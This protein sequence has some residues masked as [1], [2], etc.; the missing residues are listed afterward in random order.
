ME[1]Q[2]ANNSTRYFTCPD[3]L[4]LPLGEDVLVYSSIIKKMSLLSNLKGTLLNHCRTPRTL[5]EHAL[6]CHQRLEAPVDVIKAQLTALVEEGHLL[7][8]QFILRRSRQIKPDDPPRKIDHIGVIT[9]NRPAQL[10]RCLSSYISNVRESGRH[11]SYVV[12]D[13]TRDTH[14]RSDTRC[15]LRALG[16]EHAVEIAYLG[17]EEKR[18]LAVRLAASGEIP[19]EVID[20]ALFDVD[21]CG[22]SI[23]ANRNALLLQT[24]GSLVLSTDDD[25]FC[26]IALP[27]GARNSLVMGDLENCNEHWFFPSR[28]VALKVVEFTDVD[29]L[30][31][32]EEILGADAVDYLSTLKGND[33]FEV[34]DLDPF[35]FRSLMSGRARIRFTYAG[36]I[37]DSALRSPIRFLF[38]DGPSRSRFL[39]NEELYRSA[40]RSREVMR[41]V[42]QPVLTKHSWCMTG[43]M[44]FDNR[45]ILPPFFPVERNEDGVYGD[46]LRVTMKDVCYGHLPYAFLHDPPD[47]RTYAK[48]QLFQAATYLHS[49]HIV[50]ACIKSFHDPYKFLP[51]S[52]NLGRLGEHLST[53]GSLP[54]KDFE[55][56]VR[57]QLLRVRSAQVT[58]LESFLRKH[59][60]TPSYWSEDVER[61][62]DTLRKHLMHSDSIYPRDLLSAR[63][64]EEALLLTRQQIYKFGQLLVWWPAMFENAKSLQ[65]SSARDVGAS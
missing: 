36:T 38:L 27:P 33:A 24:A 10:H 9:C 8:E 51:L 28:E 49:S 59:R 23:G 53:I 56:L 42:R 58:S 55:E 46:T 22:L 63:S 43:A 13:D 32:H 26:H 62:I 12:A 16:K 11:V 45:T 31:I 1:S 2:L 44:A 25:V 7:P 17:F 40:C 39:E 20:F 34:R 37:G 15:M 21:N 5:E 14:I 3:L 18:E 41:S 4:R 65:A 35:F 30:A 61:Y 48:E 19:E 64:P 60:G 52:D 47:S 6:G 50:I 54:L 29:A 57:V